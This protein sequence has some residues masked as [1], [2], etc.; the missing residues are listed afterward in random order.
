MQGHFERGI[1]EQEHLV[2]VRFVQGHFDQGKFGSHY[3]KHNL[4]LKQV[5]VA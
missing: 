3:E 2:Q 1:F 4:G 5:F